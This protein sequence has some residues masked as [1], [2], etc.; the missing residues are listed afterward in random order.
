M[1]DRLQPM[2]RV[3]IA[4]L[5]KD[6][7]LRVIDAARAV[8]E[9]GFLPVPHIPARRI[10]SAAA[11]QDF[12]A[13][14]AGEAGVRD[15][16]VI[17]GDPAKP[18]GAFTQS[19]DILKDGALTR[20]GYRSVGF[21]GHPE[22]HPDVGETILLEALRAKL[23]FASDA[24]LA[25]EIV[26]Q[27]CF[28]PDLVECWLEKVRAINRSVLVRVGIPGPADAT[29]LIKFAARCGVGASKSVLKKYGLSLTR[30]FA[31][32]SPDGFVADIERRVGPA[33]PA[34]AFHV[35]PFGGLTESAAWMDNYI[36]RSPM[37]EIGA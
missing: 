16:F 2:T 23:K 28:D 30:L 31:R 36:S 9:A 32:V 24:G 1:R 11:L 33:D 27:F 6:E 3:S 13:R 25:T 10:P 17:A 8:A 18:A 15:L 35:Y 22:G 21:A 14:L 4:Y 37:E 29:T 12:L 26:T 7:P 19:L 34:V 20:L 5:P